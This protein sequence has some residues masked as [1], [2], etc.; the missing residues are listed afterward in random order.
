[1]LDFSHFISELHQNVSP[2]FIET[3][4]Q[5]QREELFTG[6]M[7][8]SHSS[9]ENLVF[10]F[11]EGTQQKLYHC[12][13]TTIE[14]IPKQTWQDA[15]NHQSTSVGFLRLPTE[16]MRFVRI[17]YEAPIRQVEESTFSRE[18]LADA[19][20]TWTVDQNPAIVH[21]QGGNVNA[22]YLFA[23]HAIPVIEELSFITGK[24]LFSISDTSFP[25]TLPKNDYQ[26]TR[27]TSTSEHDLWREHELRLAFHP[28]LRMLMNRFNELAGRV[29]TERLCEHLSTWVNEGGWDITVTS[30]GAV[31]R[32]YFDSF[33]SAISFYFDLLHHF[34]SEASPAIGSRMAD[35]LSREILVKLDPYRRELLTKH[36]YGQYGMGNV[37]CVGWR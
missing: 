22:Y 32:H 13:N 5:T 34:H 10:T 20:G 15:L 26:A 35:G 11:L 27:Y 33:E 30:N 7:R 29:L 21:V 8:L 19:A 23:G 9:D 28:F 6:L 14:M 3:L 4:I 24:A 2:G 17:V 36:I 31:N 1:M 18:E 12:S 25:Q 16:A 37:T